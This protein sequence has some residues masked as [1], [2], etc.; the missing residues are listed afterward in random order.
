MIRSKAAADGENA[1]QIYS[2][3]KDGIDLILLDLMM[4]GMGGAKCLQALLRLDPDVMVIITSG[5]YPQGR[6]LRVIEQCA[7]ACLHKPYPNERLLAAIRD[8]L[9]ADVRPALP[10]ATPSQSPQGNRPP[11]VA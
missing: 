8:V 11:D 1:L 10:P 4:P 6:R 3:Q 5:H 2:S 9:D 7:R